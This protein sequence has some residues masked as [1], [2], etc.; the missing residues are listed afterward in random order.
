MKK[1]LLAAAVATAIAVPMAAS[2][3]VTVYGRLHYSIDSIDYDSGVSGSLAGTGMDSLDA[4]FDGQGVNSHL[5]RFGIKGSEDLGNGLSAV[6]QM[7][8]LIDG[9][10]LGGVQNNRNTYVALAGNWGVAGIGQVD[11][12][13]KSSTASLELFA[14]TAGDYQQLG[15][16]D[17]RVQDAVFY[18]SPNWNGFSFVAAVVMPSASTKSDG[19]EATSISGTYSNGPFFATLAYE[20]VTD[21]WVN[22]LL[23]VGTGHDFDKWRLGLGYTANA[24]HV[25]FIYED[26]DIDN[27]DT[28]P[29]YAGVSDDSQSWQLSGSY[30]MGNNVFKLAYGQADDWGM[31]ATN[32]PYGINDAEQWT[33]GMDHKLSNRTTVYAVY[34][35]YSTDTANTDWDV[36]SL[37]IIHNF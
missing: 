6:F 24:F 2:A 37:G 13:F 1:Q 30:T 3:D 11:T 8:F 10:D 23:G 9:D 20:S 34:S 16:D 26:R 25:G 32:A 35:D 36:L 19:I 14:D 21:Q 31:D 4:G 17:I 29:G 12:P 18:M 15:F 22:D 27:V 7:E 28:I 33:I 5:S